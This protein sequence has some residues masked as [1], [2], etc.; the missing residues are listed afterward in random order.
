LIQQQQQQQQQNQAIIHLQHQS[1][2]QQ[3]PGSQQQHLPT[4]VT[5]SSSG[6]NIPLQHQLNIQPKPTQIAQ[7]SGIDRNQLQAVATMT[8]GGNSSIVLADAATVSLQ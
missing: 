7:Q 6:I 3:Q 8:V 4:T 2:Q 5:V 1:P